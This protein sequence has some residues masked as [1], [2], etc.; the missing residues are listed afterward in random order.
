MKEWLIM[1]YHELELLV[2]QRKAE[3]EKIANE[4][5]KFKALKKESIFQK[6]MKRI[7]VNKAANQSCQQPTC[8]STC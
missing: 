6:V 3:V 2:T 7:K 5:W 1:F 4:A 8:C